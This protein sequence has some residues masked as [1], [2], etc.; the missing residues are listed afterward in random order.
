[1]ISR[2]LLSRVAILLPIALVACAPRTLD[3]ARWISGSYQVDCAVVGAQGTQVLVTHGTARKVEAAIVEARRN[4]VRAVI[5]RGVTTTAC[6]V[7]PM[8]RP[9]E[10]TEPVNR[11]FDEFFGPR[12]GY[13]SYVTFV[14]EQIESRVNVGQDVRVRTTVRVETGR[15]RRD[16]EAAG[17]ARRLDDVFGRP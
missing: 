12:G 4:A 8:L 11:Y 17:I 1:M 15:L 9:A 13:G 6:T 2:L 10:V 16:L 7:P 14:G 3:P 5:F